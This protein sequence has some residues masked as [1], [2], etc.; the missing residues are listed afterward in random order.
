MMIILREE[1]EWVWNDGPVE[2]ERE[3]GA[4]AKVW[5]NLRDDFC[6]WLLRYEREREGEERGGEKIKKMRWERKWGLAC[7]AIQIFWVAAH[8]SFLSLSDNPHFHF[9]F[10]K[11]SHLVPTSPIPNFPTH[12][13]YPI[14]KYIHSTYTYNTIYYI[15][16]LFI[17]NKSKLYK[18]SLFKQINYR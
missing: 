9:F 10:L 1:R 16:R 2:R 7:V 17:Q 15:I 5:E 12:I 13:P 14:N 6:V 3:R 4:A 8:M 11:S 18:N